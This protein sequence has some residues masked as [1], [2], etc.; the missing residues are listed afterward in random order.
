MGML[1]YKQAHSG[2]LFM[3]FY[4]LPQDIIQH[5]EERHSWEQH[6]GADERIES[7]GDINVSL[8]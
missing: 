5:I 8:H 1:H 4:S 7:C 2:F 3:T 6:G